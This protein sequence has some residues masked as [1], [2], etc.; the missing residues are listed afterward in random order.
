VKYGARRALELELGAMPPARR[1]AVKLRRRAGRVRAMLAR[2]LRRT[3][4]PGMQ[5][6]A[7]PLDRVLYLLQRAGAAACHVE[8]TDH[9]GE[10]GAFVY[11]GRGARTG[12]G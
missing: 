7:Y 3:G 2:A 9:G 12:A 10:L 4:D 11:F 5:M 1:L 8:F 6:N